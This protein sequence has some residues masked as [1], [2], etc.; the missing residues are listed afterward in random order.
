MDV[1]GSD[2]KIF[3]VLP[4]KAGAELSEGQPV[5]DDVSEGRR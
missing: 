3:L 4:E 1:V 5:A 2:F